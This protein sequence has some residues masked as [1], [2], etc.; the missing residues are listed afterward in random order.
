MIIELLLGLIYRLLDI[1]LI[2]EIPPLPTEASTYINTLFNHLVSGASILAN[3]TPLSY[4]LTLFGIIVAVDV[5]INIY[6]FVMWII[7]KIPFLGVE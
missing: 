4:L 3:Y 7:K 5:G 1:L 6:K 2:F